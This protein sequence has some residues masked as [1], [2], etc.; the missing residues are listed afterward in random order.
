MDFIENEPVDEVEFD[1][2]VTTLKNLKISIWSNMAL[3][4]LKEENWT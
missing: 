4:Y 2:A 3:C 1:E